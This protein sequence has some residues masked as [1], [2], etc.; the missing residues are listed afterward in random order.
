MALGV[1]IQMMTPVVKTISCSKAAF[2]D[3]EDVEQ[4]LWVRFLCFV[5][6]YDPSRGPFVA[7]AKMILKYEQYN[8]VRG[9]RHRARRE[10][11]TDVLPDV[12]GYLPKY[13]A[14]DREETLRLLRG[15][16]ADPVEMAILCLRMDGYKKQHEIAEVLGLTRSLVAKKLMNIRKR[17]L[18]NL[19]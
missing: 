3:R 12:V 10:I 13:T 15:V 19:K 18:G 16:T 4:Q 2:S 14:L 11:A 6:E 8:Y 17:F 5:K 9:A 1:L 7:A